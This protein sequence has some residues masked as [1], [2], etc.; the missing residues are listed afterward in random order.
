MNLDAHQ[1]NAWYDLGGIYYHGVEEDPRG[2]A[3]FKK[4]LSKVRNQSEIGWSFDIDDEGFIA[5]M[6]LVAFET[7]SIVAKNASPGDRV[8]TL[9]TLAAL[10]SLYRKDAKEYYKESE[11]QVFDRS[12]RLYAEALSLDPHNFDVAYGRA[13]TLYSTNDINR[14]N[15]AELAYLYAISVARTDHER[16]VAQRS[17]ISFARRCK[18]HEAEKQYSLQWPG[19]TKTK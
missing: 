1:A 2:L 18:N 7:A 17:L 8:T 5:K 10:I 14:W 6:A 4:A 3:L 15:E 12:L 9:E 16:E 13:S 19:L 11:S